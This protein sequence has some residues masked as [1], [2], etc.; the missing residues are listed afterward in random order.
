MIGANEV[1]DLRSGMVLNGNQSAGDLNSTYIALI[2]NK[3]LPKRVSEFRPI[4]LC[5][6]ISYF[7]DYFR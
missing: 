4:S 1:R 7:R 6:V 3:K 5:N 2:P